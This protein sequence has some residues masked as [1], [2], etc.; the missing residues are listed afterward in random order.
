MR[1]IKTNKYERAHGKKPRGTG[2]WAFGNST[3]TTVWFVYGTYS[4]AKRK[5][6]KEAKERIGENGMLF[7]LP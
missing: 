6:A 3:E 1:E 5:A 7:V 2:Y 4:E